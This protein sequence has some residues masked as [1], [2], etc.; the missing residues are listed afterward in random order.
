MIGRFDLSK[1]TRIAYE[2]HPEWFVHNAQG[3]PQE[4][5][6]TY[7]AC[8]NGGWLNHYSLQ[9]L[10]EGLERYDLDWCVFQHDRLPASRLQRAASRYVP[11]RQLPHRI[12]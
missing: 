7:Q 3:E 5:N 1:G 2:A 6:G 10:S 9:I 8:V 11:L 4:Y 12:C